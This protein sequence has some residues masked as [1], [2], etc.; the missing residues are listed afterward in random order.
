M[1][2]VVDTLGITLTAVHEWV[3]GNAKPSQNYQKTQDATR[4]LRIKT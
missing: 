2:T 1:K 3:K 4:S